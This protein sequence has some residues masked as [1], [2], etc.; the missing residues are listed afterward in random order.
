MSVGPSV[1]RSDKLSEIF[2][3]HWEKLGKSR[4]LKTAHDLHDAAHETS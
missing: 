1:Q 2:Q 4:N 3:A